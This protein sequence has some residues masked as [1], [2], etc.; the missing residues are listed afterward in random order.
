MLEN[1]IKHLE[2]GTEV[3]SHHLAGLLKKRKV[4]VEEWAPFGARRPIIWYT[5]VIGQIYILIVLCQKLVK[6]RVDILHIQGKYMI[7]PV[8]FVGRIL[9]IPTVVTIRDYIVVCPIGLCLFP[10]VGGIQGKFKNHGFWWFLE[11]EVPEFINKY[12]SDDTFWKRRIRVMLLVRGWVVS[13]WIGWWVKKAD[14]VVAVSKTV[15]K[16]L[17]KNGV[18]SVVM[19]NVFDTK[20][21]SPSR[22]STNRRKLPDAILFVGKPSYG[23]GYDLFERLS[24]KREFGKYKFKLVGG[25]K[26]QPYKKALKEMEKALVVVVPSRWPEPFG[27]VALEALMMGTPVV[28]TKRGGLVEIVGD[29]TTGYLAQPT[30]LSLSKALKKTV[31]EN[32]QLRKNIRNRKPEIV[33]KFCD[34]PLRKHLTLY[35]RLTDNK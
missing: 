31:R 29:G 21:I 10:T 17:V 5:S 18:D 12:H 6:K 34:V 20:L 32:K 22:K 3:S 15:Q 25:K 11:K 28:A 35:Y 9:R 33:K 26:K 14:K 8:I 24:E 2:G 13:R 7:P 19:N 30:V 4:K 1:T 16:V 27:R 23:K